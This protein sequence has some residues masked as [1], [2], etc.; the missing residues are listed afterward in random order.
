MTVASAA[1]HGK[2]LVLVALDGVTDRDAAQALVGA[3]LLVRAD[4]LPPPAPDEFYYHEVEGFLVE[5]TEGVPLGAVG[6]TFA[7]GLND[8]LVVRGGEREYL[9]PVIADVIRTIDRAGRRIV[10][11]AIPGLLE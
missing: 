6:E 5:T 11:E 2:G 3:R 7:T 8:V 10:I 4:E 1:P 9:I